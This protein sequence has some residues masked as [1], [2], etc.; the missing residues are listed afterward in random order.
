MS[1]L[2]AWSW[3]TVTQRQWYTY[4]ITLQRKSITFYTQGLH[5]GQYLLHQE[6]VGGVGAAGATGAAE[7]TA[8]HVA[9]TDVLWKVMSSNIARLGS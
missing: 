1:V 7:G 5:V 2:I 4:T 9:Y 3:N 8:R 6:L